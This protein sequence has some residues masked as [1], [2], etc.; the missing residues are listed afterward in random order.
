MS[1]HLY[2][3]EPAYQDDS[4][5]IVVERLREQLGSDCVIMHGLRF[6][7]SEYGDVEID[8]L[9]LIPA[10]GAI[11]IEVKGGFVSYRDGAF[12]QS[13][14]GERIITPVDQ[15]RHGVYSLKRYLENRASWSRGALRAGWMVCF[16]YTPVNAGMGPEV[17]RNSVIGSNDLDSI[18]ERVETQ[19]ERASIQ[20]PLPARGWVDSAVQHLLSTGADP[21]LVPARTLARHQHVEAVTASRA[22]ILSAARNIDRLE[23]VGSAGTGKSWLAAELARRWARAGE[24][25]CFVTY[26]QGVAE[27]MKHEMAQLAPDERPSFLGTFHALAPAWGVPILDG[28]A[29]SYWRDLLPEQMATAARQLSKSERF[30]AFIVDEAQDFTDSWWPVLLSAARSDDYKLAVFR[31]DEQA[32]FTE[33]RGSPD[34]ELVPFILDENLRNTRHIVDAFRPLITAHPIARGEYGPAVERVSCEPQDVMDTADSIVMELMDERGWMPEHIA[35]LT[36]KS[37][38]NVQREQEH[39]KDAYWRDFCSNTDVF[40][41]TVGSFKGLERPVVV[42]AVNGFHDGVS[43]ESLLYAGMSRARDLLVI[44]QS[45][46]AA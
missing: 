40:Y 5:R 6:T 8:V 39:D 26:N 38:H 16:P 4:E 10:L 37:R 9:V 25:V 30:S 14:G 15:A 20:T 46:T 34:V 42:L 35:L 43:P 21:A 31:D 27:V 3:H 44:V 33:R 17:P 13:G 7:D 22:F 2:P 19:L 45:S 12:H 29:D 11:V 28:Q 36:T 1:A 18:A 24:S 23:F 32:I 41:S